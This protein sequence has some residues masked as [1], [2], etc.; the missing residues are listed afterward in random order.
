MCTFATKEFGIKMVLRVVTMQVGRKFG[1]I[2]HTECPH[3][4]DR[5]SRKIGVGSE[6]RGNA[7]E[8]E[9]N[10]SSLAL[11]YACFWRAC[12]VGTRQL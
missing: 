2:Q 7:A 9:I 11:C 5:K 3:R 8:M 12:P 4:P 10:S 6:I 1:V